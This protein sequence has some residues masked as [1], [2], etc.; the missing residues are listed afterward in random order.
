[1]LKRGNP[2][3]DSTSKWFR[4]GFD[5]C[6]SESSL[7][8][9]QVM[10]DTRHRAGELS[11]F[12]FDDLFPLLP[13]FEPV[14]LNVDNAGLFMPSA[15]PETNGFY[16]SLLQHLTV[17]Y[18][19]ANAELLAGKVASL[20]DGFPRRS[21]KQPQEL[22]SQEDILLITYG[23]SIVRHQQTPLSTLEQ[24]LDTY[25]RDTFSSVHIL[26]FCPFSSDDGFA[27]I[28]Y[29]A[30]NPELGD[31]PEI[32]AVAD[33]YRLMADLVI[34]HVSSQSEW[35][36]NYTKG[37]DP[38]ASYFVEAKVGDDLSSVVRPRASP[39]LRPTET[40]GGL[41]HVWCTFSHDQIDLDFS[42][43]Q[44][45]LEFLKIIRCYLEHGVS[46]FRLDAIG[47]LWKE[48]GTPCI[49]LPQTHEV[50]RLIRTVT[51]YYASGTI[52]ITETNVPNHEN[53]T[54]FGNFNEAHVIYNFSLAPLLVHSLL[55]GKTEY[56]KRWMMSMPPAPLGCT[57]LNF[58]ASHDGIGMR[59]AEGLLSDE[60]QF[61]MIETIRGF[62]GRV[63]TRQ[64]SDGGE[65]VY[66]LNVSLFDALKGTIAGEDHHQV[67]RFLCSQTVMMGLEGIPAFYIHSL[68]ATPNDEDSVERTGQNRSIN[69]HQWNAEELESRLQDPNSPQHIVF[70]ELIRRLNIRRKQTAFDPLATQ[71]TL[72]LGEPFFAFWRQNRDRSQNIFCIHNVTEESQELRLADLNLITF[73]R[74]QDAITGEEFSDLTASIDVGPYRSLW[75]TNRV[76]T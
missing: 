32:N 43:P 13:H 72:Q 65:R 76:F 21:Q 70:Y 40:P 68:L 57:Y 74:W 42:N 26:P 52:L 24:F 45:L 44:V 59:P 33:R 63:S 20:F 12:G 71:F 1:M 23:D 15:S 4:G 30:V 41:Q 27:V 22:W 2:L 56:L 29:T 36:Q 38:G 60:E 73:D 18:P 7:E 9:N 69:R 19:D 14:G 67:E 61:Q 37:V 50:V 3:A 55:T 53:L 75:I 10:T 66:E 64:A 25:V 62:G 8:K 6:N 58:I 34:N 28:D 16:A 54:Y 11:D 5:W 17:L 35:F 49:H 48:P 46:L 51:D 31:W 47:F 39:L